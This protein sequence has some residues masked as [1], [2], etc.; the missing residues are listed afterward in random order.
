M[1]ES[2]SHRN[3]NEAFQSQ[4][5]MNLV[6]KNDDDDNIVKDLF[7]DLFEETSNGFGI[8]R[9]KYLSDSLKGLEVRQRK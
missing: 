3:D 4:R 7:E 2:D 5:I 9:N 8:Y 6:I 1:T